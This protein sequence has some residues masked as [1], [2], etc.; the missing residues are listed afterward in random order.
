[1]HRLQ[2]VLCV[3][4][5]ISA[6]VLYHDYVLLPRQNRE[7]VESLKS[8]FPEEIPP[9]GDS[10]GQIQ[11]QAGKGLEVS[12][13]DLRSHRHQYPNVEKDITREVFEVAENAIMCVIL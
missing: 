3:I 9:G 8:K 4:C 1:M 10:P 2:A 13:V 5:M 7:L 11:E 6:A 12:A